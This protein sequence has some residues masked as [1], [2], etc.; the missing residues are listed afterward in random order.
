MPEVLTIIPARMASSRLPGKPLAD[1]LGKPMISRVY[2]QAQKADLG[3]VIIACAEQEIADLVT[4]IG[5]QAVLTEP[6]LP[7]GSD[8]VY[9][10][11][12]LFDPTR[13]YPIVLNLQGDMPLIS[14]Q[15][16]VQT[17][18]VLKD[19][20]VADIATAVI[21]TQDKA[22]IADP[23]VVKA[24]LTQKGQALYFSRHA[25]PYEAKEVFHHIGIYAYRREALETF[26]HLTP[27][28]LETQER[29]EQLRALEHGMHIQCTTI[30]SSQSETL[31]G[32][33]TPTDLEAIKKTLAN[34]AENCHLKKDLK[35]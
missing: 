27:S 19:H 21:A 15:V 29:L 7:S 5:A 17:V 28:P 9:Q 20:P 18:R 2:E 3:P 13:I 4:D 10:A 34:I 6:S 11:A 16:L 32:V 8:R 22:E 30:L 33:D 26:C 12:K 25:L 14:P 31:R 35:R 24:V 23:N 1:I